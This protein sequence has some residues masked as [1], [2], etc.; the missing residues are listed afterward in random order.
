V[1]KYI[2]KLINQG[3]N[4]TLDF[5]FEISDARKIARTLVAFSNTDGGK[6]LIGVKDNGK[7]AGIRS[8]E[9][10]HML[11]AAAQ[12]YCRPEI[13]FEVQHWTIMGKTILE[14][15]IAKADKR[16]C[17]A[18]HENERW[19]AYLRVEDQNLLANRVMMKVWQK[20]KRKK[21]ILVEYSNAEKTLLDYLKSND[22]ITI[23]KF[24]RL[25]KILLREAEEI[26]SDLIVLEVIQIQITEK[27]AH[28]SLISPT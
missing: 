22:H 19:L 28:Y 27:G 7:I 14:V 6:L 10:Y 26:L 8:E 2:Q 9:E 11:E 15:D 20:E 5:K 12:L 16:P 21:G 25:C 4:Q 3:E 17:L 1:S 23:S 24:C 18:Q 13:P